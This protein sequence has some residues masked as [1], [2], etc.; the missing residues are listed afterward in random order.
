MKMPRFKFCF[1]V[2]LIGFFISPYLSNLLPGGGEEAQRWLD[3][4]IA[5]I[6]HR[7]PGCDNARMR[8]AFQY[9]VDHY[10]RI[11]P[12]GVRVMQLPDSIHGF[13]N[14]FCPGITIDEEVPHMSRRYGAKV[15]IHEAMHN[16]PPYFGHFHIDDEQILEYL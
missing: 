6:E 7:I 14:P 1:V 12:F 8:E 2:A 9:T 16:F 3:N 11:G 10:R 13:N 5:Y 15:L 4:E